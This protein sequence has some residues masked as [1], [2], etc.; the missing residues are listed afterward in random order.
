[1]WSSVPLYRSLRLIERTLGISRDR[2]HVQNLLKSKCF[3]PNVDRI[4]QKIIDSG[5]FFPGQYTGMIALLWAK[6]H[7]LP[8]NEDGLSWSLKCGVLP[9]QWI[10]AENIELLSAMIL[11][12]DSS[13]EHSELS[14]NQVGRSELFVDTDE[15]LPRSTSCEKISTVDVLPCYKDI[16]H[17]V[18]NDLDGVIRNWEDNQII[19]KL[20]GEGCRKMALLAEHDDDQQSVAYK[21]GK[22]FALSSILA[23]NLIDLSQHPEKCTPRYHMPLFIFSSKNQELTSSEDFHCSITYQKTMDAILNDSHIMETSRNLLQ[24]YVEKCGECLPTK[25][26]NSTRTLQTLLRAVGSTG[27]LSNHNQEVKFQDQSHA[28]INS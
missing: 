1:M 6:S 23:K 26:S 18:D 2:F 13:L 15:L 10:L 25:D 3:Q 22:Y 9:S 20:L 27:H 21:F 12:D 17:L 19:S 14:Q 4:C 7:G 16:H 5:T 24:K 8:E 28:N 11:L